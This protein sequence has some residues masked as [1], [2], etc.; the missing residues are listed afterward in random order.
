[1][2]LELAPASTWL[3]NGIILYRIPPSSTGSST[4]VIPIGTAR[5]STATLRTRGSG[6][7]IHPV[8]IGI[9]GIGMTGSATTSRCDQKRFI[10][11][12]DECST[13]TAAGSIVSIGPTLALKPLLA[14]NNIDGFPLC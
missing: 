6:H 3:S 10:R 14:Y 4:A 2:C 7:R 11:F 13:T 5:V 8:V 12:I 1:M 9:P